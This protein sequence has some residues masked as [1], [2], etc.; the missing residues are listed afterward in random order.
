MKE[1]ILERFLTLVGIDSPSGSENEI[2]DYLLR[3]FKALGLIGEVDQCG[4]LKF[5]VNGAEAGPVRIFSAHM[6]T[7]QPGC[8]VKAIVEDNGVIR[9]DGSTVLGA[10]DKDGVAA[11]WSALEKI[12]NENIS[13]P[14]LEI[15]FT[16]S[17]EKN[18]GGSSCIEPG[19]LKAREGWVFDGPGT[20]GTIYVNGVGKIG[21]RIHIQ[22]KAAHAA[23]APETGRNA[24]LA[25]SLAITALPPGRYGNSVINYGTITGGTADNVVPE[26][27]T[28]TV[29]TRSKEEAGLQELNRKLH[30]VWQK[31]I[32]EAGCTLEF[33]SNGG[34]PAFEINPASLH[35][36][37]TVDTLKKL[38]LSGEIID[39]R[40]GCDANY[41][42]RLGIETCVVAM[43]RK[44]N[45]STAEITT[46]DNLELLTQVAFELM[47]LPASPDS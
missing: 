33:E 17:E 24:L 22:G 2:R 12:I 23:I 3:E 42:N 26:R 36:K 4:N 19:W 25:A 43:G 30:E 18:L 28:V 45:H 10:D 6:D 1:R 14:P 46:V 13:H 9:T 15:L 32:T 37:N 39:F 20:P 16:V 7:V 27:I 21:N 29:E 41:L 40:A 44:H 47:Q 11:I 34:Y 35:V 38:G 5:T 31:T 8:G